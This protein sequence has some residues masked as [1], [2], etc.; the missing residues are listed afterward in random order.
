MKRRLLLG[1]GLLH[2]M[3]A[4]AF[5]GA[6]EEAIEALKAQIDQ[7]NERIAELEV[8]ARREAA[9]VP[10]PAPAVAAARPAA[11]AAASWA[12]R[13][14]V[15]GDFRYRYQNQDDET[16]ADERNRQRIRA[17]PLITADVPGNV[18]L[19][20]GL[21]TGSD[22]PVSTNQTLGNGGSSKDVR[23]D[24]AYFDWQASD[25]IHIMGGKFRNALYKADGNS[26]MWDDD[27]R[28][29]GIQST[30]DNGTF[31][32]TALG[33]WLESD[34]NKEEEF[35]WGA[36]V[37]AR[38]R[39]G[40]VSLVGGLGYYNVDA[41]GSS[42]FFDADDCFGNSTNPDG[43]YRHDFRLI[44]AFLEAGASVGGLPVMAFVDY[45]TNSDAGSEDSGFSTG[46]RLGKAKK[47]GTWQ[48][49]YTYQDLEADAVLGLLTNSDFGKGG[50]DAKGHIFNAGY[51]LT[52]QIALGLSW[53]LTER[54]DSRVLP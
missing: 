26:L 20:F 50:T 47:A 13:I 1:V 23:V 12:E 30:F 15:S 8:A 25:E 39:V 42:C 41:A 6:T 52:D 29:E 44:E 5:A 22:D 40:E 11:P 24:L 4:P 54:Q 49:A 14:R 3:T 9:E 45:V 7:I 34:S 18:Q 48:V 35:A 43:T 17:R 32:G 27:W 31:F 36:Q 19:G 28:P 2:L 33:T 37:G 38:Q 21:A 53:F 16:D 46:V 51:A 10:A